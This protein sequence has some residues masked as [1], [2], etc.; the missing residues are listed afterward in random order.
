[1]NFHIYV[2]TGGNFYTKMLF[3]SLILTAAVHIWIPSGWIE[4]RF[5]KGHFWEPGLDNCSW[6]YFLTNQKILFPISTFRIKLLLL[7]LVCLIKNFRSENE[8]TYSVSYSHTS[9]SKIQ[10]RLEL[11]EPFRLCLSTQILCGVQTWIGRTTPC[12]IN[13]VVPDW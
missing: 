8:T 10:K 13:Y 6:G 5:H 2:H 4:H 3:F 12:L 1:M 11:N 7:P 9:W